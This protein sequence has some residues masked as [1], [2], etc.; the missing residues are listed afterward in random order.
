MSGQTHADWVVAVGAGL[1]SFLS[2]CVLPLI[3]GYL[4]M[5]SGL[6]FE[7]LTGKEEGGRRG[8]YLGRVLV[9]CLLFSV[10]FAVIFVLLG[11]SA[12][13][14]GTWLLT[15]MRIINTVMGIVVV[16]FGL[17]LLRVIPL[18]F[19]YQTKHVQVKSRLG[20]AGAPL[21]GMAFAFGWSPCIGAWLS[22]LYTVAA[23]RPP[24][25][26]AGL[27]A[28]FSATL[29]FCF[30]AAG[31][32]FAFS[33]R[34]FSRLQRIQRAIEVVSAIILIAIGVLLAIQR[35]D[36]FSGLIMTWADKV[37]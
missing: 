13:V 35:F 32:L 9:S 6:S 21:L 27:F 10:G 25:Q 28:I 37:F 30:T 2:P 17:A 26:A 1:F 34:T 12:G 18:P 5:I 3:P 11:T 23:N 31:M 16:M 33:L 24:L 36:W 20:L 15:H 19:L 22:A 8:H 29:A 7:Q 14:L 4:S